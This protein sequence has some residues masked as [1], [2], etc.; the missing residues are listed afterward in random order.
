[1]TGKNDGM[2]VMISRDTMGTGTD[3]LGKI[4]IKSFIYS[5]TEL[6]EPPKHVIF[7]NSGAHLTVEGANTVDDIKSLE[8]AGAEVL[9]CGTCAN[10]YNIQDKIAV[11]SISSMAEITGRIASVG[12]VVNI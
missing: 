12:K 11:G 2:A 3:E 6:A 10:Y 1:M 8:S 4:L 7:L 5:L 9:I